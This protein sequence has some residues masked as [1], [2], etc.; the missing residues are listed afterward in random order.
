[1]LTFNSPLSVAITF[2]IVLLI[3]TLH[4][5]R[6]Y[7]HSKYKGKIAFIEILKVGIYDDFIHGFK[8][9]SVDYKGVPVDQNLTYAKGYLANIGDID[10]SSNIIDS[11]VELITFKNNTWEDIKINQ[12]LTSAKVSINN[13]SATI[14]FDLLK[15]NEALDIDILIN[16]T[17]KPILI[18]EDIKHRIKDV[19][20]GFTRVSYSQ[21]NIQEVKS[22]YNTY[23][24]LQLLMQSLAIII[25]VAYF[26]TNNTNILANIQNSSGRIY[27]TS[28]REIFEGNSISLKEINSEK[29][30]KISIDSLNNRK[31][32]TPKLIKIN[33]KLNYYPFYYAETILLSM[34][35]IT[36]INYLIKFRF[37]KKI[38]LIVDSKKKT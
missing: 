31:L 7:S 38:S 13:P 37:A 18:L 17:T 3:L 10:I 26:F 22:T 27:R 24:G 28:G 30:V 6:N 8:S 35:I 9:L 20:P 21:D 36:L 12:D 25:L 15:Q 14:D 23:L 19:E 34:T 32:F 29:S 1:M 5:F 16:S 4:N 11:P 2:L 33:K